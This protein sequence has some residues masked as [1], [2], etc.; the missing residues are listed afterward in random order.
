MSVETNKIYIT[1]KILEINNMMASF[2]HASAQRRKN[3]HIHIYT[4]CSDLCP[5]SM[6]TFTLTLENDAF[7]AKYKMMIFFLFLNYLVDR[8]T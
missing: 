4:L 1:W 5:F 8:E 3:F 6:L 7:T 2:P